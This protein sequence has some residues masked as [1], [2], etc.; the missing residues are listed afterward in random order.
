MLSRMAL[1]GRVVA[2]GSISEYN[3]TE[4]TKFRNYF[5]VI[6]MRIQIRGMIVFDY[7]HKMGEVMEIFKKAIQDGKLKVSK[8]NEYV[9][10]APFEDVP[11]VWITLFEGANTGKLLTKIK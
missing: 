8:E 3:S 1:R 10:E 11:K 4:G 2:C 6:S 5:E 9:V 7:A